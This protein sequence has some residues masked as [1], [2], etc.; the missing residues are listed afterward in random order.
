MVN[1]CQ[2]LGIIDLLSLF[3]IDL[4]TCQNVG[5]VRRHDLSLIDYLADITKKILQYQEV[6]WQKI[7]GV[8]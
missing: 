3:L 2:N 8:K 5:Y 7:K 1:N 6:T 4:V